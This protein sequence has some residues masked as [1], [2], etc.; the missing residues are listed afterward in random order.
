M[1]A[2]LIDQATLNRTNLSRFN[3]I[4]MAD[5][6]Y[7][8]LT[9]TTVAALVRWVRDGGTLIVED[10]AAEWVAKK[11]IAAIEFSGK[12]G[13]IVATAGGRPK[14]TAAEDAAGSRRSYASGPDF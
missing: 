6:N 3:V 13:E 9:D 1:A 11:G 7:D 14:A 4:V 2:T 8:T 10:R 12:S 5:G